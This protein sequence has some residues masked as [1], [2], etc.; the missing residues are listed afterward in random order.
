MELKLSKVYVPI[1]GLG[2]SNTPKLFITEH[3]NGNDK[4]RYVEVHEDKYLLTKEELE[5]VI[6]DAC[7]T[8]FQNKVQE[9]CGILSYETLKQE[10][11]N[12]ILK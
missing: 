11:I 5:R 2:D 6:G 10:Y 4:I 3:Y 7:D 8:N 1:N 9:S 12:Q